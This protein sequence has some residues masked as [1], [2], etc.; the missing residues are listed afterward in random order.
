MGSAMAL[1]FRAKLQPGET[2]LINGATGVTGR[3]AI[4]VAKY[5]KAGKIIVTGRNEKVWPEL[6]ALG[7]GQWLSVNDENKPL[8]TAVRKLNEEQPIDIVLD[9]LWGSSAVAIL[10]GLQGH[11]EVTHPSRY[12]S[13]GGMSGDK[14]ELSSGI[15]RSTA[16][17]LMGSG[18]GSWSKEEIEKRLL[19]IVPVFFELAAKNKL[20]IDTQLFEMDLIENWWNVPLSSGTRVVVRPD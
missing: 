2:V 16:I 13:I 17:Q 3:I 8:S 4:Q 20:K 5:Y 11:G 6:K 19:E 7:A 15:L 18:L 1:L 12:V 10:S 9:Y 14:I